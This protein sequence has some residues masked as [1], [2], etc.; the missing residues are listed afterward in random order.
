MGDV[1]TVHVR[2][3]GRAAAGVRSVRLPAGATV[4]DLVAA[5]A[6]DLGVEPARLVGVAVAVDGEIAARERPLRDGERAA[7]VLPVAGG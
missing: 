7:L 1:I 2:I 6:P 3:G 4:A 5:M